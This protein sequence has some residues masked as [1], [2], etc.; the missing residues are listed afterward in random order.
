MKRKKAAL[1]VGL[2]LAIGLCSV[3]LAACGGDGKTTPGGNKPKAGDKSEW[4]AVGEFKH[5]DYAAVSG[6]NTRAS[7]AE[8]PDE[9]SFRYTNT[10]NEYTLT[11]SLY[12]GD[13]FKV[14]MVG[15]NWDVKVT[16]KMIDPDITDGYITGGGGVNEDDWNLQIKHDGKY[17]FTLKIGEEKNM[18]T[19]ERV[20]D[21]P[22]LPVPVESI[23]LNKASTVMELGTATATF[24][25]EATIN[26]S[27]ADDKDD[28]FYDS[29]DT[30][31]ATV[32][33]TGLVTAVA[34]GSTSIWVLCGDKEAELKVTV[35][36]EGEGIPAESVELNK[37]ETTLHIGQEETLEATVLPAETTDVANWESS[38]PTVV[39]VEDGVITALK[40]GTATITVTYGEDVSDE[41]V[42]TVETDYYLRGTSKNPDFI[43]GWGGADTYAQANE[44]ILLVKN[45]QGEYKLTTDLYADTEFKLAIIGNDWNDA[46]GTYWLAESTDTV[47]NTEWVQ[48]DDSADNN[49]KILM[50]GKYEITLTITTTEGEEPTTT[51]SIALE[52]KGDAEAVAWEYDVVFHGNWDGSG[53]TG[54]KFGDQVFDKDHLTLTADI[55]LTAADFGVKTCPT[56]TFD[57]LGWFDS[58]VMSCDPS[59]TTITLNP[60]A[61]PTCTAAG[62]YNVTITFNED[63]AITSIVFNSFTPAAE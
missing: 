43:A 11:L 22:A 20:D 53:W 17:T 30:D 56:G 63:G 60:G 46:R 34:K 27:N 44:G 5:E 50:D 54:I 39:S 58:S 42:V 57:Q 31:V 24:Q 15:K 13:E 1:A 55:E 33:D 21:V 36:N 2:S 37:S 35:I 25:I 47:N 26:P 18:I 38:D 48:R 9:M 3:G 19:Y 12:T 10:A 49:I 7:I 61:N 40:P 29:D 62:T 52:L 59:V 16:G 6:W 51:Y 23:T 4:Y 32:S 28:I 8:V 41:C 14:L 45:E